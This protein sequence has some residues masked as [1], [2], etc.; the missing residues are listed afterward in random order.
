[1]PA[2]VNPQLTADLRH[3]LLETWVDVTNAG[4]AVGLPYPTDVMTAASF[5][6]ATW[7]RIEAGLDD[8][9]VL[10]EDD[11]VIGWVVLGKNSSLLE[12]HWR[13]IR[14]LQV[15]PKFQGNG[16]G[17]ALMQ[18]AEERAREIGL[19]ALHLTV[20]GGTGTERFYERLGYAVV[21]RIPLALRVGPGDDRDQIYMV[22][23]LGA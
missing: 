4:G 10:T 11:E 2:A 12:G 20:R 5:A 7:A 13:T 16:Y 19:E 6:E 1:M 3:K 17:D 14:R 9:V 22:K 8:I 21:G 15:H 23:L 18:A